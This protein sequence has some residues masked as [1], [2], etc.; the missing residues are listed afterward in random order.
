V[1]GLVSP[2]AKNEKSDFAA[3][4]APAAGI[5]LENFALQP[6]VPP[7]LLSPYAQTLPGIITNVAINK[8]FRNFIV[9]P[10]VL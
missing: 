4:S 1:F 9:K 7:P 8:V 3:T 5:Y 10:P 2:D 6:S